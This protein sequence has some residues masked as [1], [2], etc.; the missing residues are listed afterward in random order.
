MQRENPD[1][2][3]SRS[4]DIQLTVDGESPEPKRSVGDASPEAL[5]DE[6]GS[7]VP[8]DGA[9]SP[10]DDPSALP[11]KAGAGLSPEVSPDLSEAEAAAIQNA[12]VARPD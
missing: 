10:S 11:T 1:S 5:T 3:T 12:P 2:K 7:R 9:T 8:G 6:E 4:D